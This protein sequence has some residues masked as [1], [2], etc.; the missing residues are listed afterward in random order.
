M[1]IYSYE[2]GYKEWEEKRIYRYGEEK[3]K[4]RR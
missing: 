1:N 2:L 4:E 3:K